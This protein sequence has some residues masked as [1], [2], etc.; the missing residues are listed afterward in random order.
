MSDSSTA[1]CELW[2]EWVF[3]KH[4]IQYKP[5]EYVLHWVKVNIKIRCAHFKFWRLSGYF[6]LL[7]FS[8]RRNCFPSS[9]NDH[10]ESALRNIIWGDNCPRKWLLLQQTASSQRSSQWKGRESPCR[11]AFRQP[12]E[13]DRVCPE[14][15]PH[16]QITC[17]SPLPSTSI[18]KCWPLVFPPE[19]PG[20]PVSLW[21]L[22]S[23]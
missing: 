19:K 14:E 13:Q 18:N 7:F 10:S 2:T 8:L 5:L 3:I 21:L 9:W 22:N 6:N 1:M 23:F 15:G 16:A 4:E 20:C 17:C 11:E 12:S